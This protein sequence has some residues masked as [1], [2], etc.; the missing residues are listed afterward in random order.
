MVN[1]FRQSINPWRDAFLNKLES[2]KDL[3][4]PSWSAI[5]RTLVT[6]L[7]L[8]QCKLGA[9]QDNEYNS[10]CLYLMIRNSSNFSIHVVAIFHVMDYFICSIKAGRQH[11]K[12]I[13]TELHGWIFNVLTD[14]FF[15]FCLT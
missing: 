8:Q 1:L 12:H 4:C 9:M 5:V 10:T 15:K 6:K 13:Y 7:L 11:N 3:C 2:V 14:S